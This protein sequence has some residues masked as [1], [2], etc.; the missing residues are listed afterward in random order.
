MTFQ[1]CT[2]KNLTEA[3]YNLRNKAFVA[4]EVY[5]IP[6]ALRM[7]WAG[8]SAVLAAIFADEIQI[9]D[10]V[11]FI[12]DKSAQVD[13]LKIYEPK[14]VISTPYDYLDKNFGVDSSQTQ[15]DLTTSYQTIWSYDGSG[16]F[17]G[18]KLSSSNNAIMYKLTLDD[19]VIFEEEINSVWDLGFAEISASFQF[20]GFTNSGEFNFNPGRGMIFG[21]S[22]K[23]EAK[24]TTSGTRRVDAYTAFTRKDA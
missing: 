20:F 11:N 19:E 6:D 5:Q 14:E 4:D 8:D 24:K 18:F 22:V 16:I 2:V 21:S 1:V 17:F 12:S 9:G 15:V 13:R 10:G 23:L 3:A 7:S